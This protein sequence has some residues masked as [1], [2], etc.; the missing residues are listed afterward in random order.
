MKFKVH[1]TLTSGIK[2]GLIEQWKRWN[3]TFDQ[4]ENSNELSDL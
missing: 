1:G 2:E 3:P 4:N